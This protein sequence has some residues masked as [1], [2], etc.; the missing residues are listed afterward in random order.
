[1]TNVFFTDIGWC[2]FK[3]MPCWYLRTFSIYSRGQGRCLRLE[4][5]PASSCA[6]YEMGNPALTI[7]PNMQE[8]HKHAAAS[9]PATG[10]EC[11]WKKL[12]DKKSLIGRSQRLSGLTQQHVR[13]WRT[14][15]CLRKAFQEKAWHI[16]RHKSWRTDSLVQV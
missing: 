14:G 5:D 4:S 1:M 2:T 15:P 3:Q 11:S 16:G 10:P 7:G 9:T 13:F 12:S 8:Y 6:G